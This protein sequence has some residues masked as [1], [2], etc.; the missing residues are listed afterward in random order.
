MLP[1]QISLTK[2]TI[3]LS[4]DPA[5][6]LSVSDQEKMKANVYKIFYTQLTACNSIT[7]LNWELMKCISRDEEVNKLFSISTMEYYSAI[8]KN[9]LLMLMGP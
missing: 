1:E 6:L 8:K 4:Y 5:I 9:G 3:Y 2:F 7:V